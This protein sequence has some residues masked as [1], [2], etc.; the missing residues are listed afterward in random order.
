MYDCLVDKVSCVDI[1][2]EQHIR[3]SLNLSVGRCLML[4]SLRID[5]QIKGKWSVYDAVRD[6]TLFAHLCQF[7][8]FHGD[9]HLRVYHLDCC[10]RSHLGIPDAAGITYRDRILDDIYL[11]L[12]CRIGH[13]RNIRQEQKSVDA[14]NVKYAHM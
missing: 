12:Q 7:R 9:R 11:I 13:K 3:I 4:C 6:L 5:R 8:R 2:E 14:G 10:Q 1:G